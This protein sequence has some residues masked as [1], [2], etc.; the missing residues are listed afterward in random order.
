M[1]KEGDDLFKEGDDL[2]K[3]TWLLQ[4]SLVPEDFSLCDDVGQKTFLEGMF[5]VRKIILGGCFGPE[6]FS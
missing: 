4:E 3:E 6:N 2:F 5:C 1:I